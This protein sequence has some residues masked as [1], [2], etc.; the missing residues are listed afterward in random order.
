[1]QFEKPTNIHGQLAKIQAI[2]SGRLQSRRTLELDESDDTPP[3]QDIDARFSMLRAFYSSQITK[4][5]S[6]NPLMSPS[7][8]LNYN[9]PS[10][11]ARIMSLYT[12][13]GNYGKKTSTK[14]SMMHESADPTEGLRETD[15]EIE[16]ATITKL[17][18]VGWEGTFNSDQRFE[19]THDPRFIDDLRPVPTLLQTKRSKRCNTCRHIL[20]KPEAKI[21]ST[22]YRIK[23]IALSY[24]PAMTLKHLPSAKVPTL[25]LN[26][27][28]PFK[29]LQFLLTVNNPMFDPVKVTLAT[30]SQTPGRFQSRV[31]V[32]CPQ[33]EV[34]ANTDVWDEALSGSDGKKYSKQSRSSVRDSQAEGRVAEAGKVWEKGRNWTVVVVEVVCARIEGGVDE[35][36]EDEDVLE[37]PVFVRIEYEA[38]VAGDVAAGGG[39]A[40][41]DKREKRELAY[42]AVLGVGKIARSGGS[43]RQSIAKA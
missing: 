38:D 32:L 41:K 34:G 21:S 1:M 42:W 31:T 6:L 27:L 26:T 3:T 25:D 19:Q 7:G 5:N 14:A 2:R 43:S 10:S 40:E 17:R 33:F 9:S 39:S 11:L 35:L 4:T 18:T 20:V 16:A 8:E 23:L 15:P 30:P 37:I 36:A 12:G 22:R 29:P 24:V 28:P 13:T